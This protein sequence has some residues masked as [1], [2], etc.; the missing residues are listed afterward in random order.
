M[1]PRPTCAPS[2]RYPHYTRYTGGQT[3]TNMLAQEPSKPKRLN[4][5]TLQG[6][7]RMTGEALPAWQ[8]EVIKLCDSK[9]ANKARQAKQIAAEHP[10]AQLKQKVIRTWKEVIGERVRP[11]VEAVDRPVRGSTPAPLPPSEAAADRPARG[12]EPLLSKEGDGLRHRRVVARQLPIR[13]QR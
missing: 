9:N 10:P 4:Y 2:T 6:C 13:I 8:L 11:P 5:Y 7:H 1:P 12:S 3:F